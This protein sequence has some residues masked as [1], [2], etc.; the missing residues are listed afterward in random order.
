MR[1]EIYEN[2][3]KICRNPNDAQNEANI[4]KEAIKQGNR[5]D[6]CLSIKHYKQ[7]NGLS[8]FIFGASESKN[9]TFQVKGPMGPGI[10]LKGTGKHVAIT[11]GTGVLVFMDLVAHLLIRLIEKAGGPQIID[12]ELETGKTI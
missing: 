11:A 3:Q 9:T 2:L 10:N 12:A 7:C 5:D 4:I 8:K 1:P 6:L